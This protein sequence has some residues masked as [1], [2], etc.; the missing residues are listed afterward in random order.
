MESFGFTVGL[1]LVGSG[2]TVLG[3][4]G[5]EGCGERCR[6]GVD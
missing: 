5:L 4:Q 6:A 2:R 3:V 1:R